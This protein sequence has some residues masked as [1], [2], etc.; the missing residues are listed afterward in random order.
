MTRMT[1]LALAVA[2]GGT[3]LWA[4]CG[5]P[6]S[7]PTDHGGTVPPKERAIFVHLTTVDG[8]CTPVM[9]TEPVAVFQGDTVIWDVRN[10]C[11][12]DAEVEALDF[13]QHGHGNDPF[14]PG[15]KKGSV[16]R[17][18]HKPL[19]FKLKDDA[20]KG[21]YKYTFAVTDGGRLDPELVVDGRRH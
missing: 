2:I 17:A 21:K 7:A 19:K 10:D 20:E 5:K 11:S 18:E 4:G 9:G 1:R 12:A 3:A 14:E 13:M 16:H 6:A 8:A 15:A